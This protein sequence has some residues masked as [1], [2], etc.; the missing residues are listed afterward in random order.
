VTSGGEREHWFDRL[1][2]QQTRGRFLR[3]VL[4]AAAVTLPLARG[5]SAFAAASRSFGC[6]GQLDTTE[7]NKN[8]YAWESA[9][10]Y[11]ATERFHAT[12]AACTGQFGHSSATAAAVL[13]LIA[14]YAPFILPGEAQNLVHLQQC[15]DGAQATRFQ[16]YHSCALPDA[17]GF[18]PCMKGSVCEFCTGICCASS[19]CKGGFCCCPG[20]PVGCCKGGQWHDTKAEC[21]G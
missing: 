19:A 12:V 15:V 9:C 17:P 16:K 20:P 7:L 14:K 11:D 2:E 10:K 21:F 1:A 3:A 13:G 18:N 4:A 8:P 6:P 5:L